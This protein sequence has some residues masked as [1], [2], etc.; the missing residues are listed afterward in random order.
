VG[1]VDLIYQKL[2]LSDATP[3]PA[4]PAVRAFFPFLSL[5]CLAFPCLSLPCLPAAFF[6]GGSAR[7]RQTRRAITD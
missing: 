5:P 7:P 6:Y 4:A 3:R 2:L 1:T